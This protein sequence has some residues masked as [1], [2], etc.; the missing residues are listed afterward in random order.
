MISIPVLA[1]TLQRVREEE[2]GLF[3]LPVV[4]G[5]SAK[6]QMQSL[7]RM[8]AEMAHGRSHIGHLQPIHEG[9]NA[10]I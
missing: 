8:S 4:P 5:K 1:D 3:D 2:A 7:A 9:Q 10:A 6:Q